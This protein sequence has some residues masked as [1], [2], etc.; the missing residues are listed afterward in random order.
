MSAPLTQVQTSAIPSADWARLIVLSVLWGGSF[1]FVGIAV[2][3]LGAL[4]IVL[5]R[6]AIAAA[7]LIP[8]H[9]VVRGALPADL[10]TWAVLLGMSV[11]NNVIPFT[12]IAY[13][14]HFVTAG[15]ASVL[16]ATTPFFGAVIMA[17][18]GIEGMTARKVWG[19]AIGL[20]GIA[21]L[22]GVGFAD[23]NAETKGILAVL[24]ASA[25]YGV[26]GLWA[27]KMLVGIPPVTSATCQLVCSTVLMLVITSAFGDYG[28]Y[29]G[30]SLLTLGAILALAV[31]STALAYLIFF[32]IVQSAGPSAVL[33]VTMLIP[34]SAV[35]M[36]AVV[37][38]ENVTTPEIVGAVFICAG[39]GII[40]GR[41]LNWIKRVGVR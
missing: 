39:L 16:N 32:K 34:I 18:A 37:L 6:V 35:L 10:R 33:L 4:E 28:Q 13:G 21:T 25:S 29:A 5:A 23:F 9:F 41:I 15:L 2:K 40:D 1:L 14:Q 36:G 38:G 11:L 7:V 26:S 17:A 30:I 3:E 24:L 22:R 31:I 12:A 27:K 19:L 8:V 20:A